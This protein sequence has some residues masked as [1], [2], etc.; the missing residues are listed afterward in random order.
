MVLENLARY[1]GD[2]MDKR[3]IASGATVLMMGVILFVFIQP[4]ISGV[5]LVDTMLSEDG[6]ADYNQMLFLVNT[7][8]VLMVLGGLIMIGGGIGETPER[9]P[10]G[11]GYLL[12]I[13][14]IS[15]L[16]ILVL[17]AVL[18]LPTLNFDANVTGKTGDDETNMG[19]PTDN[20][21]QQSGEE[22]GATPSHPSITLAGPKSANIGDT[23]VFSIRNT[24][25]EPF[26]EWDVVFPDSTVRSGKDLMV[27]AQRSFTYT[28]AGNTDFPTGVMVDAWTADGFYCVDVLT[29]N[30][31]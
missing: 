31:H 12:I 4:R 23:I 15:G 6:V 27:G 18:V 14:G 10:T 21:G 22:S 13:F 8:K 9:V 11:A 1:Q 3:I 30:K 26:V 19:D 7:G 2:L 29:I 5:G 17:A 20:Q 28:F 16:I 24:G 25:N